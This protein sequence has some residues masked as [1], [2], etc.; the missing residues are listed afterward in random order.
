MAE[1]EKTLLSLDLKQCAAHRNILK[2]RAPE[3]ERAV[4]KGRAFSSKP[5]WFIGE[6]SFDPKG[7]NNYLVALF[8]RPRRELLY[9]LLLKNFN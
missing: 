7:I 3:A 1:E 6:F 8:L 5:E 4:C 9:R 2:H